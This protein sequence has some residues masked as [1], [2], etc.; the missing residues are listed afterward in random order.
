MKTRGIIKGQTI[1]FDHPIDLPEGQAVEVEIQPVVPVADLA[2]ATSSYYDF[3]SGLRLLHSGPGEPPWT[4][5][6]NPLM[7]AL[8]MSAEEKAE[9]E[10]RIATEPEFENIREADR[11]RAKIAKK[12]GGKLLNLSVEFV[13]EDRNR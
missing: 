6:D 13:R 12:M 4:N 1:Q 11:L 8:N 9:L 5:P 2:A 10:A 3:P 7:K